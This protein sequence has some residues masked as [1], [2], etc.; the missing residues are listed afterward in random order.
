M[1]AQ[2]WGSQFVHIHHERTAKKVKAQEFTRPE[3]LKE[4]LI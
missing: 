4:R 2:E 3:S 1:T